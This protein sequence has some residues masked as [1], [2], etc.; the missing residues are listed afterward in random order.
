MALDKNHSHML[1]ASTADF[2][3]H[4]FQA[5]MEVVAVEIVMLGYLQPS[6]VR[7]LFLLV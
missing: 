1:I 3:S 7:Y 2:D 6:L 4:N 5:V